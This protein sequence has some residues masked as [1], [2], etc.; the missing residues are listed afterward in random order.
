MI[1]S[2]DQAKLDKLAR[3]EEKNRERAKRYLERVKKDGKKQLS[4]II[5]GEAYDQLCRIRDNA[6]QAGK[7]LSFGQIIENAL[8]C[9]TASQE[10]E[11]RSNDILYVNINSNTNKNQIDKSAG[12]IQEKQAEM[13]NEALPPDHTPDKKTKKFG[14]LHFPLYTFQMPTP[15][16]REPPFKKCKVLLGSYE[17]CQKFDK[18][19]TI[20]RMARYREASDSW[21]A[22][23]D[24]LNDHGIPTAKGGAWTKANAQAFYSRNK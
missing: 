16:F 9:Y 14:I 4:A 5:S 18:E 12:P 23:A 21:Q 10:I 6:V 11:K 8:T 13:F 1:D 22:I 15:I 2:D 20:E 3:I 24:K 19:I 7:P 17:G